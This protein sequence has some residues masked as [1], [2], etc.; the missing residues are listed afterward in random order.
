MGVSSD[1]I[2]HSSKID[3]AGELIERTTQTQIFH[4]RGDSYKGDLLKKSDLRVSRTKF[5][6]IANESAP[7]PVDFI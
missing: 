6:V 2:D 3:Q 7:T 1:L 4:V 5:E